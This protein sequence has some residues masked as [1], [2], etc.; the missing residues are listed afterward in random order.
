MNSITDTDRLNW[1][2]KYVI[3]YEPYDKEALGE[4]YCDDEDKLYFES[5]GDFTMLIESQY[6]DLRKTIDD[7]INKMS[8]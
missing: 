5:N 2:I 3:S 1:L 7:E 8:L 4:Q 6:N